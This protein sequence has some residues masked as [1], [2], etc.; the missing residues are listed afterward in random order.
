MPS[1]TF[2]SIISDQLQVLNISEGNYQ[3]KIRKNGKS[4]KK[5][6][7]VPDGGMVKVDL[8]LQAQ[9][10]DGG[11]RRSDVPGFILLKPGSF[12]MII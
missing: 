9:L 6:Y 2:N 12:K 3:I 1:E 8:S 10:T 4:K 11:P 7:F 5:S